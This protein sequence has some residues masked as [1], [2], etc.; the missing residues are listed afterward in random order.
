MK[1][2]K[3]TSHRSFINSEGQVVIIPKENPLKAVYVKEALQRI[4]E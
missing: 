1:S 3:A 4:G 2:K